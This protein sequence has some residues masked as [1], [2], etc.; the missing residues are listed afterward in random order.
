MSSAKHPNL[1]LKPHQ[2]VGIEWLR[3]VGRGL[4]ADSPRSG[5]T[6]ELL[7]AAEGRTLV[8]APPHL[9]ATWKEQQTLWTP[10]LDLTFVGYN[11]VARRVPNSQGRMLSTEP[12]P[13]PEYR[14]YDTVICDEAHQLV[15]TKANWT[16][17]VSRIRCERLYLATG[18]PI[19]NWATDLLM[20]LRLLYPGDRRFTNR[21][22]WEDQ[23]FDT[24][25]PP[26]GGLKVVPPKPGA[27][28]P[29][30]GVTWSDFW[31]ENG[32]DGDS[33]RMLQREVDL[34][35]PF[36]E[37]NISVP[38]TSAQKKLYNDLKRDYIAFTEANE[39]ISAW[40]DG[41]L[42]TLLWKAS[43]GLS[44]L[45]PQKLT[46]VTKYLQGSGKLTA[47]AEFLPE[48]TRSPTIVFT[49][50]R[51][52]AIACAQLA[53]LLNLRVGTIH[54]GVDMRD[55]DSVV[56][57]FQL[58]EIDVLVGTLGTTATG[59]TMSRAT[60]EIFVEHSWVP[61]KNDQAIKRA[62]VMGKTAHVHVIHLWGSR[63]VDTGMRST[64]KGKA[65]HQRAALTA[66]EFRALIDGALESA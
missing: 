22:R 56:A 4:L 36:T 59:L 25:Q 43:T 52:T 64:V 32:L 12:Y 19:P 41:G 6:A 46:T 28:G 30:D 61:W 2:E 33:G 57:A 51:N 55:R 50:F 48:S 15:N 8:I 13:K 49:H 37:Q 7:L 66:R 40:S 1:K 63:S 5:K 27:N 17:A 39:E 47:L 35:V 44:S 42:H 31:Y 23:W 38:M 9:A 45:S 34:G 14:N 24:W 54:G 21:R 53:R 26:W 20:P 58:G 60:T 18:T 3:R 29:K 65:S 62:M 16:G 11:S 10:D